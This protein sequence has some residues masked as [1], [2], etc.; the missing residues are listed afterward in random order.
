MEPLGA[1]TLHLPG[2]ILNPMVSLLS[3]IIVG[4]VSFLVGV[5][6]QYVRDRVKNRAII[7]D[8]N[9]I[10]GGKAQIQK[11]VELEATLRRMKYEDKKT[12]YVK[13]D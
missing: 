13:F 1:E 5:F 7:H 12:Q 4:V 8:L 10:E 6:A 9:K 2:K 3:Y 11:E